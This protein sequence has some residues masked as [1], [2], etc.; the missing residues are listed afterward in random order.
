MA[1]D[2][3]YRP[4]TLQGCLGIGLQRGD[5]FWIVYRDGFVLGL[6]GYSC[7][8]VPRRGLQRGSRPIQERLDCKSICL[9]KYGC[10]VH[11]MI[12]LV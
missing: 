2:W 1:L 10:Q 7:S 12:A 8:G 11:S 6:L 4:M 3:V 9:G 5:Q